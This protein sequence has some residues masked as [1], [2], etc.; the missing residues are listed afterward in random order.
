MSKTDLKA[1]F[2]AAK[3]RT[4][5]L[6]LPWPPT[7]NLYW[8]SIVI[9][10]SVRVLISQAGRQYREDVL[11]AVLD[12]IVPCAIGGRLAVSIECIMPDRQKRDL[13]NLTKGVLDSLAHALVF[14]DDSQIDE[15][16]VRRLHVEPPGC[17]DVT[18]QQR[19][20]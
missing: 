6:R 4:I 14:V 15:L 19:S 16:I 1:Q 18:I 5:A 11:A 7:V 13:D 2:V 17:V 3:Q 20:E 9:K 8:R 12:Q 10:G